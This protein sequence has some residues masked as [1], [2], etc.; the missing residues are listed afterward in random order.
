[1]SLLLV[2]GRVEA[3][4]PPLQLLLLLVQ[5]EVRG[6][7]AAAGQAGR[8]GAALTGGGAG[9][10]TPGSG[11][12]AAGG[13]G[14]SCCCCGGGRGG[15]PD[16]PAATQ[17]AATST[18]SFLPPRLPGGAVAAAVGTWNLVRPPGNQAAGRAPRQSATV[19]HSEA[20]EWA[21]GPGRLREHVD[22]SAGPDA[23]AGA[24]QEKALRRPPQS[25]LSRMFPGGPGRRETL[26]AGDAARGG[27]PEARQLRQE[28]ESAGGGVGGR[29]RRARRAG[30]GRGR[31]ARP[32]LRGWARRRQGVGRVAPGAGAQ[33]KS[34]LFQQVRGLPARAPGPPR[35]NLLLYR[36]LLSSPHLP[37]VGCPLERRGCHL[38]RRK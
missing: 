37:T 6:C 15:C 36:F 7:A 4:Q 11:A 25:L 18:S 34:G 29:P 5:G 1:M 9:R 31:G 3:L 22:L 21:A 12:T 8:R 23:R 30:R 35:V 14:G 27:G 13:G 24:R 33:R 2:H 28:R 19:G 16:I 20:R 10:T 17:P 38:P 32:G 26:R